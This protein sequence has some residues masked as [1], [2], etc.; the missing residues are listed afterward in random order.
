MIRLFKKKEINGWKSN[1]N[2]SERVGKKVKEWKKI[3]FIEL[4]ILIY[5]AETLLA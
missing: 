3:F 1:K 4:E 2:T 5:K